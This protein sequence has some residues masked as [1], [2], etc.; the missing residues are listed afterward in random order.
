[1]PTRRVITSRSREPRQRFAEELQS[2]RA[3][4][5]ASLRQLGEQLGWDWSLFHKME[6]GET[7]GGPEVV[8]ALDEHYGTG[9]LLLTLWE[10]ALGDPT[11]FREK[12]RRYMMLEAEAL[13][14]WQYSPDILP[15]LLQ[16]SDY[17]RALLSTGGLTGDDLTRQVEA[18]IGRSALLVEDGAPRFRAIL[19]ET[20]LRTPLAKPGH[21][22]AQLEHLLHMSERSNVTIHVMEH[23]AGLH[24]LINTDTMFLRSPGGRTVAW[25]ETGYSGELIE[26]T[27]TVEQLQLSYDAV[28]DLA[29]TP[30]ASRKF[31]TQMLEEAQCDPST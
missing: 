19:S 27:D 17:A 24:A 11:Q 22:R 7:L 10:C 3:E 23:S 13:S 14:L 1:M 4:S 18:R 2:L 31:I 12:Y 15:G 21:W 20:V 30:T 16:T 5:G 6:S 26:K 25:V 9:I 8:Q 29:L 28:R